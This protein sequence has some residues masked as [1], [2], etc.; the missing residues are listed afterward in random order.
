MT[1]CDRLTVTLLDPGQYLVGD[2]M[3]KSEPVNLQ[4]IRKE[5]IG[6]RGLTGFGEMIIFSLRGNTDGKKTGT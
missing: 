5:Q 6:L 1:G 2:G 3:L 4:S